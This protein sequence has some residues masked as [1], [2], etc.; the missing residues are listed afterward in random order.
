MAKWCTGAP[1]V[2]VITKT[3]HVSCRPYMCTM[4]P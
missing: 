1:Y 4:D 2:Y 3:T